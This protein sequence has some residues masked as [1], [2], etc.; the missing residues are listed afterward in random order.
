MHIPSPERSKVAVPLLLTAVLLTL[1]I[2]AAPRPA[3]SQRA[4]L[5]AVYVH[6]DTGYETAVEKQFA[7]YLRHYFQVHG[8]QLVDDWRV[9]GFSLGPT[10]DLY[11]FTLA[12]LEQPEGSHVFAV[13]YSVCRPAIAYTMQ[14]TA[15]DCAPPVISYFGS[16]KAH[17]ETVAKTVVDAWYEEVKTY[18]EDSWEN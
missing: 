12:I 3:W 13:G 14:D 16:T 9:T 8:I 4:R 10:R 5:P 1:S 18:Y 15:K 17:L 7:A 11:P 6:D 2:F